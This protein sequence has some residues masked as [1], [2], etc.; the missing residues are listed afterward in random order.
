MRHQI[1]LSALTAIVIFAAT[2]TAEAGIFGRLSTV[3][4]GCN[5]CEPAACQ[6]C[7]VVACQPCEPACQPCEPMCDPCEVVCGDFGTH[8]SFRPLGGLF[9]NMKAKLASSSC[10]PCEAAGCQPCEIVACAPCEPMCDPCESA[11]GTRAPFSGFFTNLKAKLTAKRCDTGCDPCEAVGC[12]P[13][14]RCR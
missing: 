2:T 9:A 7:E 6:P 13:C 8:R 4:S 11:C 5:P 1:L 3:W 10:D 12:D 14:E